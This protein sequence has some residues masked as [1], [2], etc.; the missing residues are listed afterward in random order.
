LDNKISPSVN[1]SLI[2]LTSNNN[3]THHVQKGGNFLKTTTSL[4]QTPTVNIDR[5]SGVNDVFYH[6]TSDLFQNQSTLAMFNSILSNQDSSSIGN[7]NYILSSYSSVLNDSFID[8][9]IYLSER[10]D[11]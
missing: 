10:R 1:K 11:D 7:K 5:V 8:Y 9:K 4:Q 2:K 6:S 3:L